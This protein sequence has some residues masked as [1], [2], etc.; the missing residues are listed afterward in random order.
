MI[1]GGRG[2]VWPATWISESFL[3]G[4]LTERGYPHQL[5]LALMDLSF[6]D[7]IF[8]NRDTLRYTT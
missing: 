6:Q 4:E 1:Q 2:L 7:V 5:L 8:W 3:I